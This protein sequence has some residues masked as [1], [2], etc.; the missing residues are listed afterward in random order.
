MPI[1]S[2][3]NA[4]MFISFFGINC[5][6]CNSAE[7]TGHA[8]Q[9]RALAHSSYYPLQKLYIIWHCMAQQRVSACA[10]VCLLG[11]SARW[12]SVQTGGF[13]DVEGVQIQEVHIDFTI[14]RSAKS[15]PFGS[16][17]KQFVLHPRDLWAFASCPSLFRPSHEKSMPCLLLNS[18]KVFGLV[19]KIETSALLLVSWSAGPV[20][21]HK[22]P[23]PT[24]N[25]YRKH[26]T[27]VLL[28]PSNVIPAKIC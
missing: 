12:G 13:C 8:L 10:A 22:L 2:D 24:D 14:W 27:W 26:K 17:R 1:S 15:L 21:Q 5:L 20:V 3:T 4:I 25:E 6:S 16:K 28:L 23:M 18:K 9:R 19:P 7:L 11:E